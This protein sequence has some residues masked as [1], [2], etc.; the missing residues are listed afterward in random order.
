M[1]SKKEV[2]ILGA[3]VSGLSCVHHLKQSGCN[4]TVIEGRDRIGGRVWTRTVGNAQVDC[5]MISDI[6]L[7]KDSL[8]FSTKEQNRRKRKKKIELDLFLLYSHN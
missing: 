3:G 8:K 4:V 7:E 2:L 6:I 1:D 5:G